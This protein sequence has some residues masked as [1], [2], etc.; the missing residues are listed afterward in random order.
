MLYRALHSSGQSRNYIVQDLALPF[1]TVEKFIDYTTESFDIWPLWLCPLR[2]TRLPTLH[3]H[4]PETE[5]DGKTLK[6]MLNIGLWGFVPAQHDKFV[7]KNRELE[8]KL[9]ELS[10]MKRLYAHTYYKENEFWEMFDRQWYDGLRRKYNAESLPSIWHKVSVDPNIQRQAVDSSWG[11]LALQF[12]PLGGLWGIRK[13]IE[14]GEYLIVR[15]STW[16]AR[17]GPVQG[18]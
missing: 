11:T 10:G 14:R 18:R 12:W 4:F 5:A 7:V 13:A 6:P 8:C 17:G 9:R 1:A 3:P 2:Q 16:K 15:N